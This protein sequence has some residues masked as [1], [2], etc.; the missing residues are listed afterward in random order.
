MLSAIVFGWVRRK[1]C[2]H[3]NDSCCTY[4]WITSYMW[5]KHI[6]Y[7]YDWF[8]SHLWMIHDTHMDDA[9]HT[10]ERRWWR[11]RE[12]FYRISEL[13]VAMWNSTFLLK[14]IYKTD[15]S[16]SHSCNSICVTH[17]KKSCHTHQVQF[18]LAALLQLWLSKICFRKYEIYFEA[19]E[20]SCLPWP[21]QIRSCVSI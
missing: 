17:V 14:H 20:G 10:R 8:M 11:L 7:T 6:S 4:A 19:W 5:M 18:L 2:P 9:C 3:L 12:C 13:N 21:R 16:L 1:S 15:M